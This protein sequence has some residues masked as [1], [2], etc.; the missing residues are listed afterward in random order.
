MAK[1]SE[2]LKIAKTHYNEWCAAELAIINGQEYTIGSR[3]LTRANLNA[4]RE[5]IKY[6]RS[7]IAKEEA[8]LKGA[9][10]GRV[11]RVVPRDV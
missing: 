2:Y 10:R 9:G 5:E 8:K 11:Y 4:V 7:E 6:W 3:S 1:T